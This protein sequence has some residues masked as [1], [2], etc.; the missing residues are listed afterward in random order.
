MPCFHFNIRNGAELIRDD[1]GRVLPD[2][3]A[4]RDEARSS[5]KELAAQEYRETHHVD[6]RIIE[7]TD[8]QGRVIETLPL[9]SVLH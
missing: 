8:A 2:I 9:R 3:E 7:I 1:E 6:G 5:A 4:A